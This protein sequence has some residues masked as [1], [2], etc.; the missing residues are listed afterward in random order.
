MAAYELERRPES[1]CLVRPARPVDAAVLA[2]LIDLAGAG[3]PQWLWGRLAER[4]PEARG[5]AP[6]T[7]GAWR[8]ARE[9]GAFSYRHAQVACV[10]RPTRR[11]LG[12]LGASQAGAAVSADDHEDAVCVAGMLLG[13]RLDRA[14]ASED[15]A[16]YA[17]A[18][19]PVR[20]L[21]ALEARAAR[22]ALESGWPGS[23]YLNALAVLPGYRGRG[24]GARLLGAALETAAA[25]GAGHVSLV[26]DSANRVADALYRSR[27]FRER[28]RQPIAAWPNGPRGNWVLLTRVL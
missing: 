22:D 28:A 4:D 10:P 21:L 14:P 5:M 26:V 20:P 16:A 9:T 23:W 25:S 8:A 3:L 6:L 15:P 19:D 2:H 12:V 24:L 17:D 7:V 13:Y 1:R 18:P 11:G 27:G